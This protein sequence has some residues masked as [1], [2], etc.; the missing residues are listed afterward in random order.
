M[1]FTTLFIAQFLEKF[2][3]EGERRQPLF[4]HRNTLTRHKACAMRVSTVL[5]VVQSPIAVSLL[6]LFLF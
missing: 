4:A 5:T 6:G 3:K 1:R 2:Q